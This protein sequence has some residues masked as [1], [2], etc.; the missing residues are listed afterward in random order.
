M[1]Y[2]FS[3]QKLLWNDI[4]TTG[5]VKEGGAILE[6]GFILTDLHGQR[7]ADPIVDAFQHTD[8]IE[9]EYA[10]NMHTK[11]G[12]VARCAASKVTPALH[13]AKV[14]A[15]VRRHCSSPNE[16]LPLYAGS[17]NHYDRGW[18]EFHHPEMLKNFYYRNNDISSLIQFVF[19][20]GGPEF[21]PPKAHTA[22]GDIERSIGMLQFWQK[23]V[24][25]ATNEDQMDSVGKSMAECL[26][27]V[28][29][30]EMFRKA[31]A[32]QKCTHCQK[33]AKQKPVRCGCI[34]TECHGNRVKWWDCGNSC[35]N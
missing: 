7:L 4:E 20:T 22:I 9:N 29:T 27:V 2:D 6:S 31:V 21:N 8:V 5:L 23:N 35:G 10:R 3:K 19:A 17:S 34:I 25:W 16:P 11:T 12:L 28:I 13:I 15:M 30:P 24:R 33:P 1:S 26:E 32:N 14:G 18:W